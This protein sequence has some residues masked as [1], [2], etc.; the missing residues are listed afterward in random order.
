M[1]CGFYEMDITPFIGCHIPG[2]FQERKAE[3]VLNAPHAK[4]VVIDNGKETVAILCADILYIYQESYV[5]ILERICNYTDLKPDNILITAT[6][7]H[8]GGP[9]DYDLKNEEDILYVQMLYRKA[10]DAVILAYQRMQKATVGYEEKPVYGLSFVR[11]FYMKDGTLCTQPSWGDPAIVRPE[12]EVDPMFSVLCFRD[13]QGKPIGAIANFACHPNTMCDIPVIAGEYPSIL[14]ERLKDSYGQ[15]FVCVF[16]TGACGNINASDRQHWDCDVDDNWLRVGHAL[17]DEAR[18]M[19]AQMQPM[20]D[21]TLRSSKEQ[22]VVRR[23]FPSA[24]ELEEAEKILAG[25]DATNE[26]L[27][28]NAQWIVDYN[29]LCKRLGKNIELRV[30][31]LRIGECVIHA[32]PSEVFVH[33]SHAI[34]RHTPAKRAMVA[35]LC[36]GSTLYILPKELVNSELYEAQVNSNIYEADTG[37]IICEKVVELAGQVLS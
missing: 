36:N 27:R 29:E 14:G 33:F 11:D 8:S 16:L 6:H 31:A 18:A 13:V 25:A 2:S 17:A 20:Q 19:V 28:D 9:T 1:R 21:E 22:I 23:R 12:S 3:S 24:Q 34:R 5:K 30:Q 26:M 7:S 37:D 15:D 4:A 32:I 35:S 10:A